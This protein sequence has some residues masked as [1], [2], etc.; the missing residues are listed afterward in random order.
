M[1][2][3]RVSLTLAGSL[4]AWRHA[5]LILAIPLAALPMSRTHA[6]EREE[7]GGDDWQVMIGAGAMYVH[8]Y[9]GSNDHEVRPFPFISVAYR[10][11]AY[12]RGPEIGINILRLKPSDDLQIK[13][14]PIARYRRDRPEDRNSD[15]R[16]LGDVDLAIEL[17]GALAVEYRQAFFRASLVKDVAGGHDGLV[18]EGEAGIRFDL[19]DRLSASAS[20]SA[21][22][23]DGDYMSTYFSVTP[24][25]SVASGLPVF[26][27]G[28]GIK[29]VGAGLSLNYQL[30]SRWMLTAV[31]GYSRLLGDAAD[32][33]LVT[34]RGSPDQWQG[35][36]FLAYRF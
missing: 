35:G 21:S 25:Q 19:A 14:G 16:G 22:W 3:F 10:D 36:L 9:E 15:L 11:L 4:P 6:Q 29:D 18:G 8:D 23:A 1:P 12:V 26:D 30:G 17:G 32:A 2:L 34:E 20:A 31:G 5:L 28:S 33:P 27:A 7:E 24:A 13:A